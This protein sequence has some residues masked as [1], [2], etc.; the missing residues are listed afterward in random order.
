[1]GRRSIE[2]QD[3][4]GSGAGYIFGQPSRAF[5]WSGFVGSLCIDTGNAGRVS[6]RGHH[7]RGSVGSSCEAS[8]IDVGRR[9]RIVMSCQPTDMRKAWN[10]LSAVALS[11]FGEEVCSGTVF[12]FVSRDRKR[13]KMIWWDGSGFCL[14]Q[15]RL[16]KGRFAAPWQHAFAGTVELTSSQLSLFVEGSPFALNA[17]L[18]PRTTEAEKFAHNIA[19]VR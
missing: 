12:V 14:F 3:G 4:F 8:M 1:M 10:G 17:S 11:E 16:S 6:I 18:A 15:K 5:E 13:S 2:T 7:D 9:T 19:H